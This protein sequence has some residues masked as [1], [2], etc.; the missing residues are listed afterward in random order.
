MWGVDINAAR[1]VDGKR[2]TP[3]PEDNVRGARDCGVRS[4]LTWSPRGSLPNLWL[5]TSPTYQLH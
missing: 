1:Y 4:T 5:P 3:N 2:E